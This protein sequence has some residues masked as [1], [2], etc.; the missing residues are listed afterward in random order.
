[1]II[2]NDLLLGPGPDSLAGIFSTDASKNN[3]SVAYISQSDINSNGVE[4]FFL[5]EQHL[6][7][8]N[9]YVARANKSVHKLW[10]TDN[11][12]VNDAICRDSYLVRWC[13]RVYTTGVFTND[14]SMLKIAGDTAWACQIYAD[15][16]LYDQ[17]PMSLCELYMFD[18]KSESWYMWRTKWQKISTPPKPYGTYAVV[19]SGKLNRAAK[20]AIDTVWL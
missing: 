6:Q 1:M 4:Y 13:E 12:K 19:G 3:H 14:G 7:D 8:A 20:S 10:P 16:F 2:N 15:R 5:T 11:K 18:T 17:E 9:I